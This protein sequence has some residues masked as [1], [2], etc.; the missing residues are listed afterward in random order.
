MWGGP[1]RRTLIPE[2]LQSTLPPAGGTEGF[3]GSQHEGPLCSPVSTLIAVIARPTHSEYDS[4]GEPFEKGSW[5]S[6]F[7]LGKHGFV[8]TL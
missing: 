2:A 3:W 5:I 4:S 6:G 7:L 8:I 1:P